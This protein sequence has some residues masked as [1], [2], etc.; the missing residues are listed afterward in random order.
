MAEIT[1][2]GVTKQFGSV[3]AV[4][5]F[6]LEIADAEFVVF[7][8]PSGCGKSTT[9][10]M[11]AGL[12]EITAGT[13]SIDG[14]VVN[15]VHPKNRDIAM[16]FQNY[17]LYPHLS[18]FDNISFGLRAKKLPK[19]EIQQRTL[20]A[21]GILGLTDLLARRPGELSGGQKQRVAMGR[22]IVRKPKVFLFD[23]PLSNLDAKLRHK[24]RAEMKKL[25][26]QVRTTTIY[27]THDQVE[28]MTLADRIVIMKDGHIEQV[29]SPD[30]VYQRP[31]SQFVAGFIGSPSMNFAAGVLE[32]NSEAKR[33]ITPSGGSIELGTCPYPAGTKVELGFR[34][35]HMEVAEKADHNEEQIS[36]NA[37]ISVVEPMG[38]ETILTCEAPFGEITGKYTGAR[39]LIPTQLVHFHVNKE[40][41]HYF[42]AQTG[43]RLEVPSV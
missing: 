31:Q 14:K 9:L 7:V 35:E 28:A 37:Q 30:E 29:G 23:E 2:E 1:L 3:T 36:I 32:G 13:I 41:L 20:E 42:D 22:A 4:H 25:H 19:S 21:A 8:G 12:E 10:R 18:V 33:L 5:R 39:K 40:K 17:A 11:L 34:P 16:V 26:Q 27:V 6:S 15:N 24:M 43:K 38:H